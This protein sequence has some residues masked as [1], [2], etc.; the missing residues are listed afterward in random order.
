VLGISA[1]VALT[2]IT[3]QLPARSL[4]FLATLTFRS[5]LESDENENLLIAPA[6]AKFNCRFRRV[7]EKLLD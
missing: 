3:N 5:P 2:G 4:Q 7:P 1:A 6:V